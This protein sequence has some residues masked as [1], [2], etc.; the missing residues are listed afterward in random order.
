MTLLYLPADD[1]NSCEEEAHI[2]A[3]LLDRDGVRGVQERPQ[4]RLDC[5]LSDQL[6]RRAGIQ[7]HVLQQHAGELALQYPRRAQGQ[8]CDTTSVWRV[9]RGTSQGAV[10]DTIEALHCDGRTPYRDLLTRCTC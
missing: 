6:L 1:Y 8:A 3:G 7:E 9:A 10:K 2:V 5:A 4:G